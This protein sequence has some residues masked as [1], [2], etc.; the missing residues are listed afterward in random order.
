MR[1]KSWVLVILF[2]LVI[3]QVVD[4]QAQN[5]QK[6]VSVQWTENLI[7]KIDE[8]FSLE[9]LNFENAISDFRYGD[10]PLFF[11]KIA[12]DNFFSDCEVQV[13]NARFEPLPAKDKNLVPAA[14]LK[15]QLEPEV[16]CYAER[17]K[18]YAML[19]LLPFIIDGSGNISRL[20]SCDININPKYFAKTATKAHSYAA[21]SVLSTGLW[22]KVAVSE[23]GLH[24]VSYED[25]VQMGFSASQVASSQLS[26]F[27]NGTGRL[28]EVCGTDRPDD[29]LELPIVVYDGGDG[30]FGAGD[31]MVFYAKSPH[32]VSF[33]P[34][35]RT[36]SH[37]YNIYSDNSYYFISVSGNGVGKRITTGE[38]VTLPETQSVSD[39]LAYKYYEVDAINLG[40]SGQEWFGDLF[41]V[42]TQRSYSIELPN[43]KAE[44]AQF[45]IVAAS[46]AVSNSTFSVALNGSTIGSLPISAMTSAVARREQAT[47]SFTPS[48]STLSISLTFS[49]S[50]SLTKGYLDYLSVQAMCRLSLSGGQLNFN[51]G[52]YIANNAVSRYT[53]SNANSSVRV[54]DVTNPANAFQL[55]GS[56][57]GSNYQFVTQDTA[58][59]QYVAF[60][61][62]SYKS[63][64]GIG[65]VQNQNLHSSDY[66]VDMIIIAHPDFWSQA[67]RLA[68]VRRQEQ[69]LS[70]KIVTP[71]QIYNEFS[72]GA[73]DPVAIRDYMKMIYEKSGG[74]YP[75]YL[76]LFGRPSY[77]YRGRVSGT[78]LFVPNYQRPTG[79]S[80]LESSFRTNDDFFG[81]LD[82][83]EGLYA[84]GLVDVAVGRFPVTTAAQANVAVTKSINYTAARNLVSASSTQVSN[85]A[86][87]RNI[88]C[89]V[90]DDGDQNEHLNAAERCAAIIQESNKTINLDKIY[91]DAYPQRSN[92]GGQRYPAVNTAINDR[93]DRGSLFLTYVGHSGKDG[94][95][96][97][98][99]LEF[100]DINDWHNTYNQP[101]IMTLSCDF[102]WYD[103]AMVSP[104]EACFFNTNGGSPALITTSR[105][106]YG[107]SNSSYAQKLFSRLFNTSYG[108]V[109]TMG[110]MNRL[111]KNDYGGNNDAI[112]MFVLIG[113][114]SMPLAVPKFKVITDSVNGMSVN[115]L[116]DTLKALSQVV[117][118]GRVT[119]VQGNTLSDFNGNLF[120]SFFDKKVTVTTLSNDPNES[121]EAEF[122]VQK[123]I[124]FK[125][126]NTVKNGQFEI[127]FTIP[128][129][130]NYTYGNGK[131]SYYA[132][133]EQADAAGY[134]D[135]FIVGGNSNIAYDDKEGPEI[136]VYLNDENFVNK[137]LTNADPVLIIKLKDELGINTTG[138]G[139]GHDLVAIMDGNN[140]GQIILNDYYEAIQDSSNQGQVRYQLRDLSTG[141]H[142]LKIRAWDI[143]NNVSEKELEFEVAN[144]ASLT[145]DHVLN[146]PNPFTTHTSFFFEHNH[147]GE[148]LDVLIQIFTISGK[149]IKT[150]STSMYS[151]GSRSQ[152]IDWDG[153]DDFGD[154]IGKGT[155][156]YRLKVRTSDGKSAEKIEKI[157]LL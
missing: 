9:F 136:D 131:F 150:I 70:I 84:H 6:K 16:H 51:N 33:D 119:D 76:L 118:K 115:A 124:L 137:G 139:V 140:D 2:L 99:I 141:T 38:A 96:H 80:L 29:L 123:S 3:L 47:F 71:A 100:S 97:E 31:Y 24:K 64:K 56:W 30:V 21:N 116:T 93:M 81:I 72:S 121:P 11:Q 22:Y 144:D 17:G 50:S 152:A 4:I 82:D 114:P 37:D 44:P 102:A 147:P 19:T 95:A 94:W 88:I 91:C 110:E 86:D 53:I 1:S 135:G 77:D 27:G 61:G 55:V 28:S 68:S 69:G 122:D 132:R 157:V 89:F 79:N 105:V 109:R 5:I 49:R 63:V 78:S 13:S 101:V 153:R 10:L 35:T 66:Q 15:S 90:A 25:L 134:F 23:T 42:T 130:I 26:V 129:D 87:W 45:K 133:S 62:S 128:K 59:R 104:A 8:D 40:E 36:F 43:V 48:Q 54:W 39:Y 112:S 143:L 73:Q 126:N 117:V 67:E 92:S 108:H 155:Y 154:K 74:A 52:K 85:W 34:T 107:G 58:F 65:Q 125:G 98:R 103:R 145:L 41:D 7:Y 46:T 120:T 148:N 127:R 106:A 151:E 156:I 12:V 14:L 146:Y 138:N 20:L 83:G 18:A 142:K 149:L 57:N 75:K 113:D 111:A 32:R 60:D